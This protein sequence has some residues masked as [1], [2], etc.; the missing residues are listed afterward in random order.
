MNTQNWFYMPFF[1]DNI[2]KGV[3]TSIA[4][5]LVITILGVLA[6]KPVAVDVVVLLFLLSTILSVYYFALKEQYARIYR[7]L[8][9][10]SIGCT[11]GILTSVF[12]GYSELSSNQ[13]I[14]LPIIS[15]ITL[16]L[17]YFAYYISLLAEANGDL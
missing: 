5:T 8:S 7:V 17:S 1:K 15:I 14:A 13:Q 10:I 2:F 11:A 6:L 3:T 12:V 9:W 16:L 4:I